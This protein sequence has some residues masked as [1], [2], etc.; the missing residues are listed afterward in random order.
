MKRPF[1]SI[2]ESTTPFPYIVVHLI[3]PLDLNALECISEEIEEREK[4]HAATY[5]TAKIVI[6]YHGA[7]EESR[8]FAMNLPGGRRGVV[9]NLNPRT[10]NELPELLRAFADVTEVMKD[11]LISGNT[12]LKA[13]FTAWMAA[14]ESNLLKDYKLPLETFIGSAAEWQEMLQEWGHLKS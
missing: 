13:G 5:K 1:L 8:A 14:R 4:K 12:V 7:E 3:S 2:I 10:D 6:L 9:Y 11:A